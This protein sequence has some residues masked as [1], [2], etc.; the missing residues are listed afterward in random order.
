MTPREGLA[1]LDGSV[2]DKPILEMIE[3]SYHVVTAKLPKYVQKQ[4]QTE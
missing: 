4:L 2:P 3:H 1:P